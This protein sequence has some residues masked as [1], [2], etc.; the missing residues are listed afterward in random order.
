MYIAYSIYI[1]KGAQAQVFV[2]MPHIT[3]GIYIYLQSFFNSQLPSSIINLYSIQTRPFSPSLFSFP[4][5]PPLPPPPLFPSFIQLSL[6]V[7]SAT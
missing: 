6:L 4:F 7:Y 3:R 1:Q 2:Y 5:S